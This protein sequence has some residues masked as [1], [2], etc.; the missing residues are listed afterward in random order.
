[1]RDMSGEHDPEA[2]LLT[3]VFGCGKTSVAE[4]M[5]DVLEKARVP[6]AALDLDWL[7]WFDSASEDRPTEHQ[8]MLTN[9]SS[10][11]GNYLAVGVR[12]FIL[13]RSVRDAS[14]LHSLKAALPMPAKVVR[15]TVS[16]QEIRE[17]LRSDVTTARQD[18][19]REAE[20]Q[21]ATSMGIGIED[22]TIANDRPIREV[23]L[24]ILDRLGW[25]R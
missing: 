20:A 16:L 8:M 5:A 1:M 17:R 21:V 4:E 25:M 19:L 10:V 14:E 13:A 11:V 15:L 24:D 12:S 6:F 18:D 9:L 23:A 7:T 22:L 3:G 2:L